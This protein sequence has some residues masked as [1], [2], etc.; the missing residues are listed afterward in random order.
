[1]AKL[2]D[3]APLELKYSGPRNKTWI[4]KDPTRLAG[5]EEFAV[6]G[7]TLRKR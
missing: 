2:V 3:A 7:T 1:M 4:S 6:S 5:R